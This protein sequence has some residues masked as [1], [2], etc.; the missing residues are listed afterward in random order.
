MDKNIIGEV[1]KTNEDGQKLL[2][3]PKAAIINNS[4]AHWMPFPFDMM[5][6]D[7]L[8]ETKEHMLETQEI[9]QNET[10]DSYVV[11]SLG[12]LNRINYF[13]TWS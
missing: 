7:H 11:D 8:R 1:L 12:Y 6:L 9:N 5:F 13:F 4:F 10:I 3:A 2:I